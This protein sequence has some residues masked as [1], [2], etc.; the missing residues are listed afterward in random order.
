VLARASSSRDPRDIVTPDAFS[1]APELLGTPLARPWRRGVAMAV[2]QILVAVVS[3]AGWFL[4]GLAAAVFF[5]RLALRPSGSAARRGTRWATFGSAGVLA[6][7][8]TFGSTWQSC[9]DEPAP[10]PAGDLGSTVATLGNVGGAVRDVVALEDAEDAP[11]LR[12]AATGL[13]RRM[14]DLGLPPSAIREM[15]D[16]IAVSKDEPWAR[17]AVDA[18]LAEVGLAEVGLAVPGT[19]PLADPDSLVVAYADA[20][21]VADSAQ[22]A[23][24]RPRLAESLAAG[25]LAEARRRADELGERNRELERDLEEA[26]EGPG[27]VRLLMQLLDEVGIGLGWAALYFTFF[28]VVWRGRT[29][30]KRLLRIRVIRLDGKPIGWWNAFN[31]FGGYAASVFTGLLGFLEMF[32]DHNRM[33]LH[34]R[35]ASTVVVQEG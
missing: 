18:A 29:P 27:V 2:D 24:L 20:L 3:A 22:A 5:F 17:E 6:L 19:P 9:R 30:G 12:E 25:E 10:G 1:V 11:E 13:A 31:R 16:S 23:A 7:I 34:D 14:Q 15:L 21:R 26:R 35:I 32:W 8:I 4:L 28:P 33:A